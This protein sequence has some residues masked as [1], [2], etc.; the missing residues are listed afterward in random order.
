M[1]LFYKIIKVQELLGGNITL[2]SQ[3]GPDKPILIKIAFCI[4]LLMPIKKEYVGTYNGSIS[5]EYKANE[6]FIVNKTAPTPTT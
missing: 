2:I 3:S 6:S 4:I 1:D 5:I